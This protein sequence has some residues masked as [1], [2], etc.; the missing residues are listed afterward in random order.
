MDWRKPLDAF[1]GKTAFDIAEAAF[2]CHISQQKTEYKVEDFGP[3]D[4]ARFGLAFSTVGED[5]EKNDFFENLTGT[6]NKRL[7]GA[8]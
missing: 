7:T 2:A 4:N 8:E 3:Y 1:G 6:G 5:V